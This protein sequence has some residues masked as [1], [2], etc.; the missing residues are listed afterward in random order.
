V[1]ESREPKPLRALLQAHPYAQFPVVMDG[2]IRGVLTRE[3]AL[4]ALR[5]QRPPAL[6]EATIC[7]PDLSLRE[8][9]TQ[10]I[11]SKTGFLLLQQQTAGPLVGILTLHDILRAQ[12]AAAEEG[13]N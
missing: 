11:E 7:R 1:V 10:L 2:Q 13:Y 6:A 4:R 8:V 3:E 5:E 9:E 12:Q